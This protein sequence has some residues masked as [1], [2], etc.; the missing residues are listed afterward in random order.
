MGDR[1]EKER[2]RRILLQNSEKDFVRRILNPLDSP[3]LDMGNGN[4]VTH[5]MAWAE[6]TKP[7]G[8]SEFRVYP[9]V[10]M[11]EDGLKDYGNGAYSEAM[12]R[13]EYIGFQ[14]A[15]DAD[16]FSKNYKKMWSK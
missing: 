8:G 3:T 11:D 2:I 5:K 7:D 14:N 10:L 9:T 15:N 12:K 16:W 13:G 6:A 1:R 4:Y